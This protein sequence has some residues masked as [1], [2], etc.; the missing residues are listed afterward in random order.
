[1]VYFQW[2]MIDGVVLLTRNRDEVFGN[3]LWENELGDHVTRMIHTSL[4][5][6]N[7]GP[8]EVE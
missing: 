5:D 6:P 1:M 3:S 2:P 7:H 4:N 8:A